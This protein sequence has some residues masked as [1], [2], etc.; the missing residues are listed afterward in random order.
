M[1]LYFG[2]RTI[3]DWIY[4]TEMQSAV[5]DGTITN[6]RT[7]FSRAQAEKVYVQDLL[8]LDANK[9][10]PLLLSPNAYF[11]VCGDGTHMSKGVHAALVDILTGKALKKGGGAG[12]GG[13]KK[14]LMTV[15]DAE[16]HLEEMKECGRYVL[17]IW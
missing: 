6:L 10:L 12:G 2:C 14:K 9:M 17:D 4:S 11:Y 7:A 8:R 3:E 16:K 1:T 5:T 13:N 15:E